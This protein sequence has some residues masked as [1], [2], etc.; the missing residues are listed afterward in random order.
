MTDFFS[1]GITFSKRK[2]KLKE[3]K[4]LSNKCSRRWESFVANQ[5]FFLPFH[6]SALR[7]CEWRKKKAHEVKFSIPLA[8]CT[9]SM[10][11]NF[12]FIYFMHGYFSLSGAV[13]EMKRDW[14]WSK[15]KHKFLVFHAAENNTSFGSA[16]RL[17]ARR[18]WGFFFTGPRSSLLSF[19]PVLADSFY[20]V[21]MQVMN[22]KLKGGLKLLT[23]VCMQ[24]SLQLCSDRDQY[25][26]AVQ[27]KLIIN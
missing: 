23:H 9:H 22:F 11:H 4:R 17:N 21:V 26:C 20:A 16:S 18:W 2:K 27:T 1:S 5:V 3:T 15:K 19:R 14:I 10:L 7:G 8:F 24:I 12:S 13:A 25:I 6:H